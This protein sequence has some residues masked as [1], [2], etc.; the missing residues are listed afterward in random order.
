M[1]SSIT[2]CPPATCSPERH[3]TWADKMMR[4]AGER[5]SAGA[6][7][8]DDRKLCSGFGTGQDKPVRAS[9]MRINGHS[10]LVA[11]RVLLVP[12]SAHH[13]PTYHAWMQDPAIREATASEPLTLDEEYAMQ[14]S[15]RDDADKLTFIVCIA[16]P[17]P[18][19]EIRARVHDAPAAMIGDVNLFLV[20][21]D[22]DDD[23]GDDGRPLAVVGELEIMIA[24]ATHQ[25][26]GYGAAVLSAF[27]AYIRRRID[28]ILAEYCTSST[29][30]PGGAR[31]SYLR[32]KIAATNHPSLRLFERAGFVRVSETPNF[33]GELELRRGLDETKGDE[34]KG[35][36][37]ANPV[38]LGYELAA[39]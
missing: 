19:T 32:V 31:L 3:G 35:A 7:R 14:R 26:R 30:G 23:E 38:E 5:A 21:D 17:S 12:Y 1:T 8:R 16:P 34:A 39:E 28:G 24:S 22:D 27:M 2:N 18:T 29:A 6:C 20:P 33:F 4:R 25:N 9:K 37:A 11:P 13:V 36:G 10:A 15:W